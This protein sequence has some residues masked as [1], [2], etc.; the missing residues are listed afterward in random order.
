MAFFFKLFFFLYPWFLGNLL[1]AGNLSP[2]LE[3]RTYGYKGEN[4]HVVRAK[5]LEINL[6]AVSSVELKTV[7]D[8]CQSYKGAVCI[9][10][11]FFD[12]KGSLVGAHWKGRRWI[13]LPRRNLGVFGWNGLTKEDTYDRLIYQRDIKSVESMYYAEQDWWLDDDFVIGG[14]PLLIHDGELTDL[15]QEPVQTSF[16]ESDYARTAVCSREDEILFA[17]VDGGDH[18]TSKLGFRAGLDLFELAAFLKTELGCRYA[19]NLD[20]GSSS[21]LVVE[22]EVKSSL[23]FPLLWERKVAGALVLTLE[24]N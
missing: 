8:F 17:V 21:T 1:A 12:K 7:L 4:I 3:Y 23:A 19:L 13:N 15:A 2:H 16:L 14:A 18:I 6:Q 22:G 5:T 20:G 9:N 24:Q 10:S 11:G